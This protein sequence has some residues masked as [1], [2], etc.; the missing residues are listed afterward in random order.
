MGRGCKSMGGSRLLLVLYIIWQ[1]HF[2]P[3]LS[4]NSAQRLP[5]YGL[6]QEDRVVSRIAFGSCANQSAP[7]PIWTAIS[8]FDPSLFIWLGDNIYADAKLPVRFIGRKRTSGP[9][10]NTPRF[11][12][13]SAEVMEQKYMIAKNKSGYEA[14]RRTAQIIGTWDDH[15]YGLNDAGKEL[16]TKDVSQKLML[17]FFDEPKDSPRRKQKGVYASYL[18]GPKGK[19]VKVI[20][21]DTRYHRDPLGSNG[22]MLGET[23]WAWF[24]QELRKGD[25]QITIIAS[26]IQVVSNVS[27][28]VQPFFHVE[29][30]SNFPAEQERLFKLIADN[31]VSGVIFLSG[32]VHF[33]EISRFDC[34]P[35]GYPIYDL[36]SSG[37]TQA[38][39]EL[40]NPLV[41]FVIRFAAWFVPNTMRVYNSQCRYKSCV[42]GKRNFGS[43]EIDWDADPVMIKMSVRDIFGTTVSGTEVPLSILQPGALNTQP[44]QRGEVRRHCTLDV[45]LP[46]TRKYLLAYA[47]FGTSFVLTMS[48]FLLGYMTFKLLRARRRR[49]PNQKPD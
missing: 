40:T 16:S 9:F 11:W 15:D 41:A 31:N 5:G 28:V 42:Y 34:G 2:S 36:T 35:V 23:Q 37:L 47:F 46:W 13:V 1:F 20:L 48:P 29:S 18:Y 10:K 14:L 43:I 4:A 26:S 24:E 45:D 49:E 12:P 38:V 33:C 27:A 30:W 7:Q 32:D 6:K 19:R 44:L 3:I 17:D 21:L 25:S 8:N 39:E 22:A